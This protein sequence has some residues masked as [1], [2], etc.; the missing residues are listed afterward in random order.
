MFG[1]LKRGPD[2]AKATRTVPRKKTK[3]R[4]GAG[5]MSYDM[6]YDIIKKISDLQDQ[7]SRHDSRIYDRIN[8]HD[9]FLQTQPHEP[10]KRA[11]IE[12]MNRI[13]TQPAPVR[14][15]V[16]RIIKTDE[17]IMSIIGDG[18]MSAG[19]VAEKMGLSREHI[20]RRISALTKNGLLVRVQ[21][22]KRIFYMKPENI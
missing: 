9:R 12:I 13:Y 19:D 22:G 7:L 21:E 2:K 20:S 15:E 16:V 1:F 5:V 8:E 6:A 3:A 10:M 11:A 14:N 18:K 17:N 4:Y